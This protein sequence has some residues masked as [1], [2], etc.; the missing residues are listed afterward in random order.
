[1][2]EENSCSV[3]LKLN[4][5]NCSVKSK[6]KQVSLLTEEEKE[7]FQLRTSLAVADVTDICCNHMKHFSLHDPALF[8]G[9]SYKWKH[10]CYDPFSL[11]SN[12]RHKGNIKLTWVVL[13][14]KLLI[15]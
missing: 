7:L 15:I 3:A 13:I 2:V 5:S 1:M 11:H 10:F 8:A 4:L 6:G 14:T 9:H 12:K